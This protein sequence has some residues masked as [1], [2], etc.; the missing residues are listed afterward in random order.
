MRRRYLWLLLVSP[1]LCWVIYRLIGG[2]ANAVSGT[3][4]DADGPVAGA[5]VRYQGLAVLTQTDAAGR[6]SLP[7][8]VSPAGRITASKDGYLI[9]GAPAESEPLVLTLER[10]PAT[11][12]ESYQWVEPTPDEA[13]RHNCGNCHQD[14]YREWSL[15]GHA[16]SVLN[17]RFLNLYDG[18]DWHGRPKR[19]WNFL[20]EHPDGAGVCTACHAPT[21][22]FADRAY[23]DLRE[24]RGVD[25]LGV[26]CDYCHK[27]TGATAG[28]IGFTHGRFGLELLRPFMEEETRRH[29]D[30]APPGPVHDQVPHLRVPA[31]PRRQLFFGPLDDVDRGEDAYSTFYRSSRYCASCHEGVV[32]GVH[33]YSTYSEWLDSPARKEG[34]ECQSCHM[35]PTGS[36][37][38][39]AP[40]R[41]GIARDPQTLASHLLFAHSQ[42]DMLRRSLK[43]SAELHHDEEG[44]RV[45]VELRADDVGHRLPTGFV[46]RNLMLI[47]EA[48][49]DGAT[50]RLEHGPVLP[51]LAGKDFA[52]L[53]GR[54]FAKQLQ[55]SEGRSPAPFWRARSDTVDTRLL[56][57]RAEH[58]TFVFGPATASVRVRLLYRRFWPEVA[59]SKGWPD[60]TI[61]IISKEWAAPAR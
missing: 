20:A 30:T 12:N 60:Q 21:V 19:G 4:V 51:P 9:A 18:S 57:G 6:F 35:K 40:G 39:I 47:V 34:K 17:R 7:R 32:F 25:S 49:S 28:R 52:G 38:N 41:G 31:S 29:G 58:A 42:A 5:I 3:V 10:L 33:A 8:L 14:I 1:I 53:P 11:D 56:P 44:I 16:R 2:S 43:V 22:P 27:V 26:H 37:T 13:A 36:L 54:L 59:D 48:V 46:D 24:A 61:T 15:S 45:E 55:D 50:A 23:Y